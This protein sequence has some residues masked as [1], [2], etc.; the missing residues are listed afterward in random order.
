[1]TRMSSDQ[2]HNVI[3]KTLEEER[4]TLDA[5][6]SHLT[7]SKDEEDSKATHI[8]SIRD[9]ETGRR[10]LQVLCKLVYLCVCCFFL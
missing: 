1:M 8:P 9:S 6:L 10:L 4:A 3:T 2:K 7:S 5:N